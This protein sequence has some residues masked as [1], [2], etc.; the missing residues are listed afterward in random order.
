MKNLRYLW[1]RHRAACVAFALATA[2]A[3]FFALRFAA[4]AVYW[5]DPAHR[6]H[7]IEGWMTPGYVARSWHVDPQLVR[8]ALG[9]QFEDKRRLTID[10]IARQTGVPKDQLI[11]AL[12]DAIA[13]ARAGQ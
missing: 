1:R 6:D 13:G 5:S 2:I 7:K 8:E 12:R 11:E 9:G 10:R 3:L 4:F